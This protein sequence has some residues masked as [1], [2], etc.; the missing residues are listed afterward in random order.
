MNPLAHPVG[1]QLQVVPVN[2]MTV[3]GRYIET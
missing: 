1:V 2:A 3:T